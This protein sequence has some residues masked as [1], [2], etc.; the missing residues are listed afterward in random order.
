MFG[1]ES[2]VLPAG[3]RFLCN[4]AEMKQK[5]K[6]LRADKRTVLCYTIKYSFFQAN[7][8][9]DKLEEIELG[10]DVSPVIAEK[11]KDIEIPEIFTMSLRIVGNVFHMISVIYGFFAGIFS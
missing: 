11:G 9:L 3:G 5:F 2:A 7:F 1:Q 10:S 4:R 6:K 8:I